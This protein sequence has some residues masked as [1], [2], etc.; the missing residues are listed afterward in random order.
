MAKE[1]KK[2][3]ASN[4]NLQKI[5]TKEYQQTIKSCISSGTS[6]AVFGRRGSGKTQIAKEEIRQNGCVEV[7]WNLSTMER[8]DVGGYP[9]LLGARG[10]FVNFKLPSTYE[11]MINGDQKVVALLDEVDKAEP[12]LW[13]PLLEFTQFHTINGRPLP[14]LQTIIMTGNLIS[15]GGAKPCLPLLDRTTKFLIEPDVQAWMDWAGSSRK[16]HPSITSYIHDNQLDLYGDVDPDSSYADPSP[17]SWE[18]ASKILFKG[19]EENLSPR[20]LYKL[21]A[22]CVGNAVGLKYQA[23]FD[24]YQKI[25]PM[26]DKLEK[27]NNIMKE[28]NALSPTEQLIVVSVLCNRIAGAVDDP[29]SNGKLSKKASELLKN[30]AK[31]LVEAPQEYCLIGVRSQITLPRLIK[32]GLDEHEEFGK[33]ISRVKQKFYGNEKR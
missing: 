17:R 33:V 27:G 30:S 15:E 2:M 21:V 5:D 31:L 11:K 4:F 18:N 3:V 24:H 32:H 6:M 16:I 28:Y 8:V 26:L 1:D 23:Y 10:D 7:Y 19:E 20:L 14:N 22:G 12:S 29:N 13:A 25:L 9:D